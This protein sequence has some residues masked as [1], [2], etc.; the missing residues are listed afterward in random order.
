MR[1]F[2]P[3]ADSLPAPKRPPFYSSLRQAGPS[4]TLSWVDAALGGA[5]DIQM[6][7]RG[8]AA[9]WPW[10]YGAQEVIYLFG[11]CSEVTCFDDLMRHDQHSQRWASQPARGKAPTR[12]KGHSMTLLGPSWAQQLVVFGGWSGDSP[13]PN[14]LKAYT[15]NTNTWEVLSVSGTPPSARWAHTATAVDDGQRML[16][17]GGEGVLPANILTTSTLFTLASSSGRAST[18]TVT[19][20]RDASYPRRGWG[21]R[22]R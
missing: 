6:H 15:I 3:S 18:R 20:P 5:A 11:G 21:T 14:N 22:R 12:R 13:T 8:G 2:A 4:S 10:H 9:T 7:A 1:L 16:V 19:A 17:V